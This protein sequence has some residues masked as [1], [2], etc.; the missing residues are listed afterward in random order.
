MFFISF[1][2]YLLSNPFPTVLGTIELD[3]PT[4][5]EGS[6]ATNTFLYVNV[7]GLAGIAVALP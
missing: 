7:Y 5:G 4:G 6:G 3:Y 2:F 1:F